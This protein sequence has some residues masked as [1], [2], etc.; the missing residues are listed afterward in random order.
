MTRPTRHPSLGLLA[1]ILAGCFCLAGS[2]TRAGDKGDKSD[3]GKGP[4][5]TK[6]NYDKLKL[7]MIEKDVVALLGKPTKSA[8]TEVPMFG[9]VRELIWKADAVSV[10]VLFRGDKLVHKQANFGAPKGKG[11]EKS[12]IDEKS[13][14]KIKVGMTVKEVIALLGPPA[15]QKQHPE[16][17]NLI[18][19]Y[20]ES[21]EIGIRVYILDGEVAGRRLSKRW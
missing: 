16:G 18:L 14:E 20:W 4:A 7:G 13:Y 8:A 9:K 21:S 12:K 5:V 6:A 2:V 1:V 11:K 19:L 17:S 15:D 3:K 10:V